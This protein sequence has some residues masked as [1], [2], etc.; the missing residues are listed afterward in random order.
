M[1]PCPQ[2][3]STTWG[4]LRPRPSYAVCIEQDHSSDRCSTRRRARLTAS[5]KS[6]P[7]LKQK[8]NFVRHP[9]WL[10]LCFLIY[11]WAV[12]R[13]STLLAPQTRSTTFCPNRPSRPELRSRDTTAHDPRD[14]PEPSSAA[15]TTVV[16]CF[17]R[18]TERRS[19]STFALSCCSESASR[20]TSAYRHC[21]CLQNLFVFPLLFSQS[22][23]SRV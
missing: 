17:S 14:T 22:R 1:V 12:I 18:S 13:A 4:L 3:T 8:R 16:D 6:S 9:A 20:I 19:R 5:F 2:P 15:V 7:L 21:I 11:E 23:A 10:L